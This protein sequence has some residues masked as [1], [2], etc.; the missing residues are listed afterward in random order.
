MK[1]KVVSVITILVII[2]LNTILQVPVF[3]IPMQEAYIENLGDCEYHLQYWKEP[4]G[5][6]SYIVTTVVG[7]RIN[8]NL[9]YAYCLQR[10]KKGVGGEQGSY[11]VNISDMLKDEK[12]GEP[13]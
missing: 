13:L 3:A 9:H 6:W 12:F 7:Y 5:I 2:L 4:D 1:I 11:S 8:G 10:E